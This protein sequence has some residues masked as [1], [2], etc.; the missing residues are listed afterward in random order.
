MSTGSP[1]QQLLDDPTYRLADTAESSG[2]VRPPSRAQPQHLLGTD[3]TQSFRSSVGRIVDCRIGSG[4]SPT[5]VHRTWMTCRAGRGVRAG[6]RPGCPVASPGQRSRSV[7]TGRD[8][9]AP[10]ELILARHE[11]SAFVSNGHGTSSGSDEQSPGNLPG[12]CIVGRVCAGLDVNRSDQ[13]QS[14][15][16]ANDPSGFAARVVAGPAGFS[17]TIRQSNVG[18]SRP[19][20]VM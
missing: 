16:V 7:T 6:R 1:A 9:S 10:G 14:V 11:L 20:A 18:V 2:A 19:C 5:P 13:G 8:F 4:A 3:E 12:L 17:S 15:L